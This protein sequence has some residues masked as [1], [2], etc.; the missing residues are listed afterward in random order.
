M[1]PSTELALSL[2]KP[3]GTPQTR[4]GADEKAVGDIP[5]G[6]TFS[7]ADPGLFKDATLAFSRPPS[8][9][10]PDLQLLRDIRI[11]G[12]GNRVAWEGR[13]H[14]IP[15]H[16]GT[17]YSVN[18]GAIG[19]YAALDDDPSFREVYVGR[20][21]NEF[22]EL[23]NGWRLAFNIA[24]SGFSVAQDNAQGYPALILAVDGPWGAAGSPHAGALMDP[25]PGVKISRADFE[26]LVSNT[27]ASFSLRPAVADDD[28]FTVNWEGGPDYAEGAASGVAAYVPST[29]R[30]VFSFEWAHPPGP[31]GE[32]GSQYKATIRKLA[33]FGNH[34][35]PIQ[36]AF[37]NRGVL[38]SDV[39]ADIVKRTAPGLN[40]TTGV[41]GSIEPSNYI[42][43]HLVFR[44]PIKGSDA[45]LGVNAYHQRK[46]GVEE[47][48]RFFWRNSEVPR[49]R[50]RIRRS[51][52]HGI[53]LLGPQ[54]DAAMNGVVVS[55]T[56]PA[57]VTRVVGPAGCASA[58]AT[59]SLLEDTSPANPV[60]KAGIKRKWAEL[61]L[62][63]VTDF[64][65]AIQVGR[66]WMQDKLVN[67]NARGSITVTGIIQDD[68]TG[69]LYPAWYMRAGDSAIVTDGDNIERRIIET[70]YEHDS[71]TITCNL[72]TT[73][74]KVEA[75]MERMGVSLV[76]F[77]E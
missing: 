51:K 9:S 20:D 72:D 61:T 30:R 11:Y 67:A 49:K 42:I 50:W 13:L 2:L 1:E 8:E 19:H 62:S 39:M 54:A 33:W 70:N 41:G 15:Q 27:S 7:T 73:P 37:P 53:D 69:A 18:P 5:R 32:A 77:A 21:L 16:Y 35:L 12:A 44:G 26:W 40:F 10:W 22:A 65:G 31:A 58:D 36:G 76:G 55:F 24:Y 34:G 25:G 56:D 14:E 52:G 17:D 59:S 60:N 47:G 23:A 43:P 46:W 74:H 63:F 45:V 64:E 68:E 29:P 3:D 75:L 4:W 71:R 57:G 66:V 38:A 28:S 6:L 48:K